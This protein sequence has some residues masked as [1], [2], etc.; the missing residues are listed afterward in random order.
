MIEPANYQ[1]VCPNNATFEFHAVWAIDGTP[2]NMTG[3][4]AA[5]QVRPTYSSTVPL[6][7]LD[8]T[9]G[10]TVTSA[11][12]IDITIDETVTASVPPGNYVYDLV[13]TISGTAYRLLQGK[14]QH[15]AGVT[16]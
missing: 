15:L 4:L 1:M 9:S 3:A 6:I 10:I 11:G 13:I 8:E 5:M 12:V 7:D 16:R 14:W 2:V